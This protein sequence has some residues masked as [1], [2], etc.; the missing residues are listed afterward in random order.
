MTAPVA[1][2]PAIINAVADALPP[3]GGAVRHQPLS[4]STIVSLIES[5]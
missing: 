1:S 4:P 3:L 2:P 5:A